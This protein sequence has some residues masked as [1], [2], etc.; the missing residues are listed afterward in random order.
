[1]SDFRY[2]NPDACWSL[3]PVVAL[4]PPLQQRWDAQ[5]FAVTLHYHSNSDLTEKGAQAI[6]DQGGVADTLQFDV[7][8]REETV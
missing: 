4:V 3:V 2:L 8:N 7:S 6:R 5:G 1:M